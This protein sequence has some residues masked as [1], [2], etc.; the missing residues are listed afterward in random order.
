MK[1]DSL[2]RELTIPRGRV[3]PCRGCPTVDCTCMTELEAALLENGTRM[4][5]ATGRPTY[6]PALRWIQRKRR[7]QEKR[8]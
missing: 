5:R 7:E 1:E 2:P 4:I 8:K 3:I 6:A